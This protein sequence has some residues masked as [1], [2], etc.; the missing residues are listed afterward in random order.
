MVTSSDS[1]IMSWIELVIVIGSEIEKC[2]FKTKVVVVVYHLYLWLSAC[3][4]EAFI[5]KKIMEIP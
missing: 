4:R 2:Y 5:K 3:L 1:V